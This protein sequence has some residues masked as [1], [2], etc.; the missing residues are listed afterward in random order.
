MKSREPKLTKEKRAELATRVKSILARMLRMNAT[1]PGSPGG[2]AHRTK[3]CALWEQGSVSEL[4]GISARHGLQ[5]Q[6][7]AHTHGYIRLRSTTWFSLLTVKSN[8]PD[9]SH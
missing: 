8:S 7:T 6:V 5:Q 2:R 4:V 3:V 9:Q 1:E